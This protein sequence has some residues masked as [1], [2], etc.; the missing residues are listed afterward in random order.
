MSAA[1]RLRSVVVRGLLACVGLLVAL[2]L[3]WAAS[4]HR[5][6]D[7]DARPQPVA[8]QLTP[9]TVAE[10]A[11]AYFALMGLQAP[12]GQ[13]PRAFG[14]RRWHQSQAGVQE[15]SPGAAEWQ[16]A[17]AGPAHAAWNCNA[18][19]TDCV[20]Q[21]WGQADGLTQ[22][23]AGSLPGERC[24]QLA[25]PGLAFEEALP[26]PSPVLRGPQDSFA[27]RLLAPGLAQAARCQRWLQV[28]AVLA[29][30]RGEPAL[31][32]QRLQQVQALTDACLSGAR[33]LV[34]TMGAATMAQRHWHVVT[35]LAQRLP[36]MTAQLAPLIAPLPAAATDARH[37]MRFEAAFG[38]EMVREMTEMPTGSPQPEAIAPATDLAGTLRDAVLLRH[39][40]LPQATQQA[41]D[42]FWTAALDKAGTDPLALVDWD[43]HADAPQWG[44]R[45]PLVWRNTL[46]QLF[47]DTGVDS[48]ADYAR[49]QANLLLFHTAVQLALAAR[50]V[51][52]DQRGQWLRQQPMDERLRERLDLEAGA[53]KARGWATGRATDT[54]TFPIPSGG[55]AVMAPSSLSHLS[56]AATHNAV[57][58][59][60][61]G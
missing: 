54:A 14:L 16:T 40:F 25:Q 19:E 47:L 60:L 39:F 32:L 28:S 50:D 13:A 34:G 41:F 38:R 45:V 11:N 18:A 5:W 53:V 33:S 2:A 9:P 27:R 35:D 43:V 21:W 59:H 52:A 61:K 12:A 58:D 7:T 17:A 20:V 8:L 48:Y 36:G 3:A 57:A 26:T 46:G 23:M 49:R 15:E 24:E 56:P 4:N 10:D 1:R 44:R 22:A 30:R 29:A 6:T 51:P 55:S 31:M 42:R 37:W